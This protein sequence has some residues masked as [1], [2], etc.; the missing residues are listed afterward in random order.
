MKSAYLNYLQEHV[1]QLTA[2]LYATPFVTRWNSWFKSVIYL[3]EYM[4]HII[5]F[6]N[7]YEDY[8]SSISY[9]KECFE[10]EILARKI[11]VQLTFVSEFCPKIMKIIDNLEGSDYPFAHILWSKFEDL[12]QG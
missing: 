7:E 3:N 11:R 9:L 5:T 1:S 4:R 12:K 6:L 8:N 10:N 2:K